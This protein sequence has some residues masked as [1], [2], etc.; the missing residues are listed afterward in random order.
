MTPDAGTVLVEAYADFRQRSRPQPGVPG[1]H[2]ATLPITARLLE[3]M[4]RLSEA[5]ARCR[6]AQSVSVEDANAAV[7]LLKYALYS[8]GNGVPEEPA[9]G[10]APAAPASSN[11]PKKTKKKAKKRK[12]GEELEDAVKA[13]KQ[14]VMS[15]MQDTDMIGIEQV[16]EKHHDLSRQ[17]IEDALLSMDRDGQLMYRDGTIFST[18]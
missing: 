3:S 5:H 1:F 11:K 16:I 18:L 4:V 8:E 9:A 14:S 13:L 2:H 12:R 10:V 6:L 7:A 15:M 17:Q